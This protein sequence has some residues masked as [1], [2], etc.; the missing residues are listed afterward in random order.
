MAAQQPL[1]SVAMP[2]HNRARYAIHAIQSVLNQGDERLEL[3]VSDTSTNGD[4]ANWVAEH[5]MGRDSRLTYFQ[6]VQKLDMTGNHNM[7]LGACR[8][9]YI[10]LIGDDDTISPFALEAAQWAL[11]HEV[12]LIAPNVVANYVWPDFRSRYFG[13]GHA[14]RLYFARR[15][16]GAR[17]CTAQEALTTALDEAGQ[18]TDGLPKIYHGLVHRDMMERIR[19]RS[20]NYFH[21]SSP[22]VS[23]AI[24]LAL[25]GEN[26][27]EVDFPLSIPGA[28]GGSNTGRSAMNTHKGKLTAESQT[29][30]FVASGWSA[31][32]PK[33]FA[34]ETVWAH[35]ALETLTRMQPDLLPRFNFARLL[36]ACLARHPE[37]RAEIDV[38]MREVST[39]LGAEFTHVAK[40]AAQEQRRIRRARLRQVLAR[41]LHP[42]A[43]GGRPYVAGLQTVAEVPSHLSA[44]LA[45]LHLDWQTAVGNLELR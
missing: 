17:L 37:F 8:G 4:L 9:Q 18:G 35:A 44:R 22:D 30:S 3:V 2:T 6:P 13:A 7:A 29:S 24:G 10:C 26:F 19:E 45:E 5:P 28:S 27:V 38:A 23:G 36:G 1:L 32:V 33:F 42:T 43:A 41:A 34:V 11:A 15:M 40:R 16:G 21:G 12:S 14:T 20:G 31:G 39:I 25:C